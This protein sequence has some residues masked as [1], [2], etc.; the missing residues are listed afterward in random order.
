M[1]YTHESMLLNSLLGKHVKIM[2]WDGT[3]LIGVLS[4]AKW[5]IGYECSNYSF[6]KTH[7]NTIEVI[8]D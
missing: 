5:K 2:L 6:R 3:I 7:V 4:R 8:Y 1:I